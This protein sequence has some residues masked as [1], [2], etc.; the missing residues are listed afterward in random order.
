MFDFSCYKRPSERVENAGKAWAGD[1]S[2]HS[3]ASFFPIDFDFAFPH[4]LYVEQSVGV[5]S[6]GERD[7]DPP[8]ILARPPAEAVDMRINKPVRDQF[9]DRINHGAVGDAYASKTFLRHGGHPLI[10]SKTALAFLGKA[11]R[12]WIYILNTAPQNGFPAL[13]LHKF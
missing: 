7:V 4:G 5:R 8:I 3:L 12:S 13:F 10:Y 2:L 1:T 9:D 11:L 6:I